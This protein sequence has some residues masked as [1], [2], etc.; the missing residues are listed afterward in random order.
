VT[1][2]AAGATILAPNALTAA[3]TPVSDT[4]LSQAIH[5][6]E[7]LGLRADADFVTHVESL[8]TADR[9]FGLA[10]TDSEAADVRERGRVQLALEPLLEYARLL[11]GAAGVH[12]DQQRG[13]VVVVSTALPIEPIAWS[14]IQALTP[15]GGSVEHRMVDHS[16]TDLQAVHDELAHDPQARLSERDAIRSIEVGVRSNIVT[17]GV[18]PSRRD[19]FAAANERL[20]PTSTVRIVAA[21]ADQSTSDDTTCTSGSC[22]MNPWRAGLRIYRQGHPG[23]VPCTSAFQ[24]YDQNNNVQILTAGHCLTV[25][26]YWM[27]D[28]NNPH[29]LGAVTERRHQSQTYADVGTINI[30]DAWGG[31]ILFRNQEMP[32]GNITGAQSLWA[33]A[34][35]MLV[36]HTGATTRYH[37]GTIKSVNYTSHLDTS[38]D[39]VLERQRVADYGPDGVEVGDS[40]GPTYYDTVAYGIQSRKSYREGLG[41]YVAVYSHIG[42]A[43]A[44]LSPDIVMELCRSSDSF[45]EC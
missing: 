1:L 16:S 30:G 24:I 35:G 45:T 12:I 19:V 27:H 18:D 29:Q 8:V 32:T 5:L 31:H 9:A 7:T 22:S 10:L 39:I 34:E 43:D 14:R 17:V 15:A 42:Y 20:F 36:C 25:G 21:N 3:L 11:P 4:T 6:R 13:G 41:Y 40:G 2:V 44:A 23:S 37:C 28:V 26:E 38:P 33:D